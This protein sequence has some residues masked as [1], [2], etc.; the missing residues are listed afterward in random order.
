MWSLFLLFT[1]GLLTD[2]LWCKS[3]QT[4]ARF[5]RGQATFYTVLLTGIQL[6]ANWE[7][8]KTNSIPLFLAYIG[9][10]AVGTWIANTRRDG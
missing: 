6:L 8:I 10:C 7:I 1:F 2:I 4:S 3:V 5:L 9:G